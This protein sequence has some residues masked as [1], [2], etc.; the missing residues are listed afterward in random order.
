M[1]SIRRFFR[2]AEQQC[3]FDGK[4]NLPLG[5]SISVR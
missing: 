1:D 2:I 5:I 3:D 4:L